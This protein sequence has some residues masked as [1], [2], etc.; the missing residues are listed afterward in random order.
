MP[1]KFRLS[2]E[3]RSRVRWSSTRTG[4]VVRVTFKPKWTR[5]GARPVRPLRTDVAVTE[6]KARKEAER[7]LGT[8]WWL[9]RRY[10]AI[11]DTVT[12]YRV[13]A[14]GNVQEEI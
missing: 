13:D 10:P 11:I 2:D 4:Y 9:A 12:I 7:M 5:R 6:L 3:E 1:T 14:L 8:E